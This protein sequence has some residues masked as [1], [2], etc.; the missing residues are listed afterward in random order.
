MNKE[1]LVV[2]IYHDKDLKSSEG[3]AKL[4]KR[5]S[6]PITFIPSDKKESDERGVNY[7]VYISEKWLVEWINPDDYKKIKLTPSQ[8]ITQKTLMGTKSTRNVINYLGKWN[9]VK[10]L[11]QYM[12]NESSILETRSERVPKRWV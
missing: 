7:D 3:W 5:I 6:E 11:K 8:R 2:E 4:I 10:H 12:N 9:K 1:G